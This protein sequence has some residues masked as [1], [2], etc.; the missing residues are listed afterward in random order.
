MKS[1][2]ITKKLVFLQS[3]V[4]MIAL[5][6]ACVLG[7]SGTYTTTTTLT[8]KKYT[9][10]TTLTA[11]KY[12]TTTKI[13]HHYT[14]VSAEE[15]TLNKKSKINGVGRGYRKLRTIIDDEDAFTKTHF[16]WNG[17]RYN[18]FMLQ[19]VF[20]LEKIIKN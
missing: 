19:K 18:I 6:H 12:T 10:T 17:I 14:M 15:F 20:K 8:A 4:L 16:V 1:Q 7:L 9:T 2:R 3:I 13:T 11:K 5:I